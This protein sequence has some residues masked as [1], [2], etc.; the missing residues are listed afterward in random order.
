MH[1]TTHFAELI[2]SGSSG[3]L[4]D[5]HLMLPFTVTLSIF[6]AR[7]CILFALPETRPAMSKVRKHPDNTSLE[8]NGDNQ[9]HSSHPKENVGDQATSGVNLQNIRAMLEHTSLCI[10]LSTFVVK[11][12]AF[13]SEFLTYQYASEVLHI[14]LSRTVILRVVATLGSTFTLACALP[15][16]SLYLIQRGHSGPLKEVWIIRGSLVS[17]IFAFATLYRSRTLISLCAGL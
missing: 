13:S 14:K 7:Y 17:A 10:I 12:I 8:R 4:L 3:F 11:R 5:R 9:C 15:L 16:L 1:A 2:A 6:V